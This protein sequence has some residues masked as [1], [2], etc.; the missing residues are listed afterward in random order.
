MTESNIIAAFT[1]EQVARL[2]NVTV[3]Q[4]RYWDST[5][6]FSPTLGYENRRLPYSRIYTFR[7]LASLKVL[8]ALRNDSQV[9][10]PHLRDVRDKLQDLGIEGWLSTTLYV[11][12][13]RVV[14]HNPSTGVRED[15]ATGQ[16]VLQ[17]PLRVVTQ[18]LEDR[19]ADLRKREPTM[20]GQTTRSKKVA[21]NQLVISGTRI[22][23]KAI[24]AFAD[25]GYNNEAI[26]KQYPSL[27]EDDIQAALAVSKVA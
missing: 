11:L 4:L 16:G 8:S 24:R 6:F 3:R 13:R 9:S 27:T 17:I 23:V 20:F 10:L 25:E 22:P 26:Q 21:H 19:I 5:D 7:D 2:T 12:N 15:V 18:G 1:E 14:F